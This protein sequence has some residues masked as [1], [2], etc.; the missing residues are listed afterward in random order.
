MTEISMMVKILSYPTTIGQHTY[1]KIRS[2]Q[3]AKKKSYS[4]FGGI[5]GEDQHKSGTLRGKCAI[6]G[7]KR[8]KMLVRK[9]TWNDMDS[10]IPLYANLRYALNGVCHQAAN[11]VCACLCIGGNIPEVNVKKCPSY[12]WSKLLYGRYGLDVGDNDWSD[13]FSTIMRIYPFVPIFVPFGADANA[14]SIMKSPIQENKK[15][16][17]ISD[18]LPEEFARL[19]TDE[20]TVGVSNI[21]RRARIKMLKNISLLTDFQ[22]AED[23]KA[24][25]EK[26]QK[27]TE[28]RAKRIAIKLRRLFDGNDDDASKYFDLL[29]TS[30]GTPKIAYTDGFSYSTQSGV[31]KEAKI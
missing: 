23:R 24:E 21:I 20:Q 22:T 27:I 9:Q 29:E 18:S 2:K 16:D 5:Y 3:F 30:A 7:R 10:T 8:A 26:I 17:I 4:C 1:V 13:T 19:L 14:G 31:A 28:H 11:R 15:L 6:A 12:F 25:V